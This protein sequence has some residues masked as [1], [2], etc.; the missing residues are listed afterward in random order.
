MPIY[1]FE[2]SE[3][4][5]EDTKRITAIIQY[6]SKFRFS[7]NL[8]QGDKVVYK[9]IEDSMADEFNVHSLEV[10]KKDGQFTT[11]VEKFDGNEVYVKF[12]SES[13][14]VV[15]I[16]GKD[17][18][19]RDHNLRI[20][21]NSDV[22]N[23]MQKMNKPAKI[24][25]NMMNWKINVER[26]EHFIGNNSINSFKISPQ[27]KD[28]DIPD[29]L[30]QQIS[31]SIEKNTLYLSEDVPKMYPLIPVSFQCLDKEDILLQT[32]AG[33]VKNN[34]LDLIEFTRHS[35]E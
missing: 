25:S 19:G 31:T 14:N 16:W 9:I 3:P 5:P 24:T 18:T 12:E 35:K 29:D 30:K 32:E 10:L 11:V 26:E 1:S 8:E 28:S 21:P 27:V 20:L 33:F 13:R 6:T 34:S 17:I 2:L 23:I 22:E 15:E 7:S 4:D